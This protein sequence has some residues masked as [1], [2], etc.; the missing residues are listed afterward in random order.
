MK[1][2]DNYNCKI[3]IIGLGYVG[4]PLLVEFTKIKNCRAT[5]KLIRRK[6]IGFDINQKRINQLKE[7]VDLTNE[8]SLEDLCLLD[9]EN[10]TS[11]ISKLEEVDVF[12]ITVPTPIDKNKKPDL[13]PL[14]KASKLIGQVLKNRD[15]LSISKEKRINPIIILESTVYPGTM[16]EICVPIIE[17]VSGLKFNNLENGRGFYCGYSPERI[18]PGDTKHRLK[19]IVKVTSGSLPEIA[20]WVDNLYASIISAGTFKVSSL[21]IAE[22]AKVIENIQRDLNIALINELAIL[23]KEMQLDTLDILEAAGTKWNF[24]P[25][26]PGLVGGHCIGVD[27]YYLTYKAEQLGCNVELILAG[28]KINDSIIYFIIQNFL[29]KMIKKNIRISSSRVLVLGLTFKENCP[30]LRNSKVL[31]IVELLKKESI[32]VDIYDPYVVKEIGEKLTNTCIFEELPKSNKYQGII[33]AVQHNEFKVISELEWKEILDRNN[34]VA[35]LKGFLPR[36]I[37]DFRL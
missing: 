33:G 11:E 2:I 34:V 22:A 23:F 17:S 26:R 31:E 4:L 14:Q 19:D 8:V 20:D 1:L 7:N 24:L 37:V 36:S 13:D 32:E 10:L 6:L 21:K 28:R 3:A 27:P 9:K 35:D 25:F 29:D 15:S 30:D 12:I 5:G 16:E 18:N